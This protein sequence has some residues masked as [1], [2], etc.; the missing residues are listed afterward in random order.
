MEDNMTPTPHTPA[1]RAA[2]KIKAEFW[3]AQISDADPSEFEKAEAEDL[4]QIITREYEPVVSAL[5][6]DHKTT[7]GIHEDPTVNK[8]D[9]GYQELKDKA[10]NQLTK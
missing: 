4:A 9:C 8:C 3:V 7:C 2:E 6:D 1:I 5:M 10:L